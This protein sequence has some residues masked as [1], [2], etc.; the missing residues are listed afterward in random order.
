[1]M[2]HGHELGESR[3]AEDGVVWQADVGDVEVN[4]LG[5]VVVALPEGNRKAD[6]PYRNR[7]TVS[8]S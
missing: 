4:E 3:V 1:M 8:Y 7:G 5:E 6:L 2:S